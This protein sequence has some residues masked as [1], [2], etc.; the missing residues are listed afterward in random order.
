MPGRTMRHVT[1][2][3]EYGAE[4]PV[5]G[6]PVLFLSGEINRVGCKGR[7]ANLGFDST[8]GRVG[9]GTRTGEGGPS[10]RW[11]IPIFGGWRQTCGIRAVKGLGWRQACGIQRACIL[12]CVTS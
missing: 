8:V 11:R 4:S 12:G 9:G 5:S 1:D 3:F 6:M 7:G 2:V 10:Q